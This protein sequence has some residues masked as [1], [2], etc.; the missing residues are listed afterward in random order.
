MISKSSRKKKDRIYRR[1]A[2][3]LISLTK[4][5]ELK[6]HWIWTNEQ[7]VNQSF[8]STC[9]RE[10]AWKWVEIKNSSA[11]FPIFLNIF[12]IFPIFPSFISRKIWGK[13]NMEDFRF[14][15]GWFWMFNKKE[16]SYGIKDFVKKLSL[17]EFVFWILQN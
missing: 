3:R 4:L 17:P 7:K 15:N 13:L 2:S 1:R 12:R 11:E 9:R 8:V 6:L 10:I 16:L 14:K 5:A